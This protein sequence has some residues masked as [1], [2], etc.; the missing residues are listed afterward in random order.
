M[1]GSME[2]HAAMDMSIQSEGSFW[3]R[4]VSRDGF[5]SVSHNFVMAW[6]AVLRDI[7][8][9]LLIAGAAAAWIPD[10]FWQQLFFT[11]HP[12]AAKIWGRSSARWWRSQLRLL[13][14]QRAASRRCCG[15]AAL[16]SAA[17]SHS[18]SP[19]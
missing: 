15:M 13:D 4:L 2:G 7:V 6:A 3:R 14:R 18:S 8:I 10:S 16:A 17:S 12:L 19:T 5:T 11:D 9:G 1:A